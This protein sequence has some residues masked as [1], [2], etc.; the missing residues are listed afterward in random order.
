MVRATRTEEDTKSNRRVVKEEQSLLNVQHMRETDPDDIVY[1]FKV[2]KRGRKAK[3]EKKMIGYVIEYQPRV[4]DPVVI[5][6]FST[7]K[8]AETCLE[9]IKN[10][11]T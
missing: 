10:K 2:G 11:K 8:G 6:R 1:T 4:E 3:V 9:E 7:L 5:A